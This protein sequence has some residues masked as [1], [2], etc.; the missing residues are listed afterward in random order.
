VGGSLYY[1]R[2]GKHTR[3]P[4]FVFTDQSNQEQHVTRYSL[5]GIDRRV[6]GTCRAD[7]RFSEF[8]RRFPSIQVCPLTLDAIQEPARPLLHLHKLSFGRMCHAAA[9][10]RDRGF[11]LATF[12][13]TASHRALTI[14][15][16]MSLR[17]SG[18]IALAFAFPPARP[19]SETSIR[20]FFPI[21]KERIIKYVARQEW[22]AIQRE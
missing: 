5:S 14:L 10:R 20:I 11:R 7:P 17:C 1:T 6:F 3:P 4:A 22:N 15:R 2:G 21:A 13:R 9:F 8:R 12:A 19:R 18:V 16:A